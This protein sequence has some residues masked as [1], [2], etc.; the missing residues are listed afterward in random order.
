AGGGRGSERSL[1]AAAEERAGAADDRAGEALVRRA[2]A[3]REAHD[4]GGGEPAVRASLAH[5][6]DPVVG[7]QVTPRA[8]VG[9]ENVRRPGDGDVGDEGRGG[10]FAAALEVEAALADRGDPA[11]D[12]VAPF[13]LAALR[14][15]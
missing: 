9:G 13:L 12:G 2:A 14:L 5:H 8:A 3:G 7:L 15:G 10:L 6:G 11:A 1:L 4:A